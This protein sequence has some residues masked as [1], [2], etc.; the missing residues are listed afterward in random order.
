MYVCITHNH[1]V[2]ALISERIVNAYDQEYNYTE[3]RNACTCRIAHNHNNY[4]ETEPGADAQLKQMVGL[5]FE[6]KAAKIWLHIF[7]A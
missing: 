4:L 7:V 6:E 2:E 3:E 5:I 1:K